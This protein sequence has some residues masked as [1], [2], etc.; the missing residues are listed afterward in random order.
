MSFSR[1]LCLLVLLSFYANGGSEYELLEFAPVVG[2]NNDES[3]Y[4]TDNDPE[5]LIDATSRI[6]RSIYF[7][8]SS[9][10]VTHVVRFSCGVS[11]RSKPLTEVNLCCSSSSQGS[12]CH[13]LHGKSKVKTI[14][15]NKMSFRYDLDEFSGAN[16]SF[17]FKPNESSSFPYNEQIYC[18]VQASEATIQSNIVE[19]RDATF[20]ATQLNV[21]MSNEVEKVQPSNIS[22]HDFPLK[23]SCGDYAEKIRHW[24]SWMA[25]VWQRYLSPF[26]WVYC[27]VGSSKTPVGCAKAGEPLGLGNSVTSMDGTLFLFTDAVLAKHPNIAFVCRNRNSASGPLRVYAGDYIQQATPVI[28]KGLTLDPNASP[29]HTGGFE[30]ISPQKASY[31]FVEGTEL[32]DFSLFAFYRVPQSP[33]SPIK[34]G[35]F[36]DGV[37]L[38]DQEATATS[39]R[40]PKKVKRSFAG[41]YELRVMEGSNQRLTFTFNVSVVGPPTF[42]DINCIDD[43]FYALEG[44]SKRFDCLLNAREG[45]GVEFRVGINGFEA[46]SAEGLR[47][48][49]SSSLQLQNQPI[50]KLDIIFKP[51]ARPSESTMGVAV[52]VA[53]LT[54]GQNFRLS[55]K[56]IN[57]YGQSLISGSLWVVRKCSSLLKLDFVCCVW[58]QVLTLT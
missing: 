56:A 1:V 8:G 5:V 17:Q 38:S 30:A 28:I 55:V 11:R 25:A 22:P 4:L 7:L 15:C 42:R 37:A 49:L 44:T 20:Y 48:I 13:R 34:F 23:F 16:F 35:W 46:A 2:A 32:L 27:E 41:I 31:Q 53:N 10:L 3:V 33:E 52:E 39:F 29:K 45:E 58:L 54:P 43:L 9:S 57:A 24:P 50:A 14:D 26:E 47:R 19:F 6:T 40:L 18:E 12:N 21:A 51:F 36:K